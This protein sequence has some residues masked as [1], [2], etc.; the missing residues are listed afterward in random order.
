MLVFQGFLSPW[1]HMDLEVYH[2]V[3][4]TKFIPTNKLNKRVIEGS[5]KPCIKVEK[6]ATLL[7]SQ[8]I[9]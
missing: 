1:N 8:E 9:V 4:V 5:A 3:A 7:K 2:M 6:W